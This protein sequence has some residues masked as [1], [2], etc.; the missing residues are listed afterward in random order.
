MSRTS[1]DDIAITSFTIFTSMLSNSFSSL[2]CIYY[3]KTY[4]DLPD[5]LKDAN[6]SKIFLAYI[7]LL[8]LQ[9]S[10]TLADL[11]SRFEHYGEVISRNVWNKI[12]L[13]NRFPFVI[14][15]L[16]SIAS[17][18]IGIYFC[19][20]F[21]PISGNNCSIYKEYSA[22]DSL[23]L[24]SILTMIGIAFFGLCLIIIIFLCCNLCATSTEQDVMP[25]FT[26]RSIAQHPVLSRIVGDF[27]TLINMGNS[28][29]ACAICMENPTAGE[30]WKQ[31]HC[32]HKY[33]PTCIDTWLITHHTCPICRKPA[34]EIVTRASGIV[35]SAQA[36]SIAHVAEQR[37]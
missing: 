20:I 21:I 10:V 27:S 19:T 7:I 31:L 22:C 2:L 9:L 5:N 14:F 3:L 32:G 36:V 23:K 8:F 16:G 15:K 4:Q 26:M 25:H 18:C 30:Q 6:L 13:S 24:I 37:V 29:D 28:D 17:A 33:H 34:S 1:S 35:N 11:W 12:T